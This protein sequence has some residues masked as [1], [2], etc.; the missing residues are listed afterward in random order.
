MT[1]GIALLLIFILYL[2][3]KHN[4]WRIAA[5]LTGGL[6][7]LCILA[8]G[9]FFGWRKYEAWQEACQEAKCQSLARSDCKT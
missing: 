7:V 6:I 9:G 1:L 8:V 5:K 3:D 4:R 2:I